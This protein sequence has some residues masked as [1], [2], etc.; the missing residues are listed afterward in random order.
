MRRTLMTPRQMMG[1][2]PEAEIAEASLG[3]GDSLQQ[4]PYHHAGATESDFE[5]HRAAAERWW[6]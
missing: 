3:N 4:R 1:C 6:T 2:W 5:G